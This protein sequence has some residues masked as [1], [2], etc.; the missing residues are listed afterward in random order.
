MKIKITVGFLILLVF[1]CSS[2]AQTKISG[3]NQCGKPD[4]QHVVPVAGMANHSLSVAQLKCTWTKPMEIAGVQTKDGVSTASDDNTGNMARSRGYHVTTMSNGDTF[5]VSYG[6]TATLKDGAVQ[7]QKGAWTFLSGSGKLK[8]V[9][10]G[11][12]FNCAAAGDAISC[13]VEGE[14]TLPK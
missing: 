11:G 1:V 2:S 5:R 10:G 9:K 12:T 13:E 14:Y 4:P 7:S 8:G 3:T 6:S